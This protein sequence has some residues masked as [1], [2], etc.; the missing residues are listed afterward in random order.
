[1]SRLRDLAKEG[2]SMRTMLTSLALSVI[3]CAG[4]TRALADAAAD[5][6]AVS[7]AFAKAVAAGDVQAVLAL[8]RDDASV[9]WPGQ[10]E[11]AKGKAAI[12]PLA[13][14]LVAQAK[15]G[16][17]VL[18]SQE[19]TPL[20]DGYIVNVGR[21][22]ETVVGPGG[23]KTVVTIRTSEVL[24]KTDGKWLYL[25]DHASVGVP[26]PAAHHRRGKRR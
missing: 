22:E 20:G 24:A 4:A 8:Y 12:E 10:G 6:R 3:L 17:V 23:K 25:V 2:Y 15:N 26:P 5:G 1:M 11:E 19:S 14:N 9:I 7:D 16:T 18:K 21:W 13:R